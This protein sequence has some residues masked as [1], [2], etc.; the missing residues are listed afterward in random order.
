MN[1]NI[2]MR[3]TVFWKPET[4]SHIHIRIALVACPLTAQLNCAQ[5]L[6]TAK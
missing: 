2:F 3:A 6:G 1:G 5:L 4:V